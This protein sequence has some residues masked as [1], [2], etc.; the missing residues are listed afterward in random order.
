VK[1][2]LISIALVVAG[3]YAVGQYHL[4]MRG[5]LRFIDALEALS[6]GGKAAEYC[7]RLHDDLSVS[8]D[9]R[10]GPRPVFIK[11]GKR[12]YCDY[13]SM[14]AKGMSLLGVSTRASRAD[15]TTERS[16]LH[17]WTVHVHYRE[18]RTTTMSRVNA[19]I[20]SQSEDRLTLVQTLQGVKLLKLEARSSLVR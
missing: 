18:T 9:D 6:I 2:I 8:I 1:K 4:S 7:E 20:D 17:P 14:A 5:S 19:S 16:W 12:E 13:V 10:T 11:G 15:I 3:A